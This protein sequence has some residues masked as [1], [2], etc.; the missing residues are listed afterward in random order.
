M[1]VEIMC[2]DVDDNAEVVRCIRGGEGLTEAT[3]GG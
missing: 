1:Q 2:E 3:G